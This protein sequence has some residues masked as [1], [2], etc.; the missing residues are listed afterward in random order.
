MTITGLL[1]AGAATMVAAGLAL[2]TSGVARVAAADDTRYHTYDELTAALR[3]L[4]K[5]H[6][7]LS[8]N[9]HPGRTTRTIE[10]LV[11]GTGAMTASYDS[12]RVSKATAIVVVK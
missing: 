5:T 2:G 3:E 9:G 7:D 10:Y 1:R 6:A 4:A 12:T 8:R 11:R